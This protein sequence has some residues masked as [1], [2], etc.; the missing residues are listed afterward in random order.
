MTEYKDAYFG[1]SFMMI[2]NTLPNAT[3]VLTVALMIL[4]ERVTPFFQVR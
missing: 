1:K 4:Y 3:T 2:G